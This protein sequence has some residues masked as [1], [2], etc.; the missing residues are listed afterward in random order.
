MLSAN[1]KRTKLDLS[2]LNMD[3]NDLLIL[4]HALGKCKQPLKSLNLSNNQITDRGVQ[5]LTVLLRRFPTKLLYLDLTHNKINNHGAVRLLHLFFYNSH[6]NEI[7]MALN[8]CSSFLSDKFQYVAMTKLSQRS[9][10]K[11]KTNQKLKVQ[12]KR[13][14]SKDGKDSA[15]YKQKSQRQVEKEERTRCQSKIDE[16]KENTNRSPSQNVHREKIEQTQQFCR[17][18]KYTSQKS[19]GSSNSQKKRNHSLKNEVNPSSLKYIKKTKPQLLRT[20]SQREFDEI[21]KCESKIDE[22]SPITSLPSMTEQQNL[23][24][25][26]EKIET[27]EGIDITE[28]KN[29]NMLSSTDTD[30]D[31]EVGTYTYSETDSDTGI[32]RYFEFGT[33]VESKSETDFTTDSED[34]TNNCL[35]IN[36]KKIQNQ[37]EKEEKEKEKEKKKEKEKEKEKKKEKEKEKEKEKKKERKKKKEKEKEKEKEKQQEKEKEIQKEI[38]IKMDKERIMKSYENLKKIEKQCPKNST[39]PKQTL[40]QL[41]NKTKELKKIMEFIL[42]YK[43]TNL[44]C[45]CQSL[46]KYRKEKWKNERKEVKRMRKERR[47]LVLEHRQNHKKVK[48]L[49]QSL[50][51]LKTQLKDSNE[52]FS[53]LENQVLS[54]KKKILE[55]KN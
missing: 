51:L 40:E 10:L 19:K 5:A 25:L 39:F 45:A 22:N 2:N 48:Q 6:I 13:G 23:P 43:N 52:T 54:L 17:N 26:N 4:C 46:Q 34:T 14:K 53:N 30:T 37:K 36:F 35:K 7:R 21:E 15:L 50:H 55:L 12:N 18:S 8:Y 3:D 9:F 1:K 41:D 42:C 20:L 32:D 24:N 28:I 29:R 31:T 27:L 47:Q 44:N 33:E 16:E 49:K 38:K 11:S